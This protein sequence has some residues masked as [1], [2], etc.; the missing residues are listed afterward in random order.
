MG[1]MERVNDFVRDTY[2]EKV[3]PTPNGERKITYAP[4]K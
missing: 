1:Y 4:K 2:V 3:K